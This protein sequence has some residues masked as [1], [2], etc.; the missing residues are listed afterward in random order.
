[1]ISRLA[2]MFP[3]DPK[4]HLKTTQLDSIPEPE[5]TDVIF[6]TFSMVLSLIT[7]VIR[8]KYVAW[9]SMYCAMVAISTERYTAADKAS[10]YTLFAFSIMSLVSTYTIEVMYVAGVLFGK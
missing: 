9:A 4:D 2:K 5:N 6:S 1:M 3:G 7:M 10:I 8:N